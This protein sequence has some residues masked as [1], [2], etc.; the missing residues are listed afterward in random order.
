VEL[1][2]DWSVEVSVDFTCSIILG[3]GL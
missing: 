1:S 3:S 2:V